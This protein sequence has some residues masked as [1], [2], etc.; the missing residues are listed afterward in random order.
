MPSLKFLHLIDIPITDAGL[1]HLKA[2]TKLTSF[3]V[4]GARVTDDGI[5]RLLAARPQLHVHIDQRHSDRDPNR[6][7]H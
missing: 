7:E 6:H 4:D 3:Y 2:A 5:E 1:A